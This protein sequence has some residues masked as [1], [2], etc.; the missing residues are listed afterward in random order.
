M[1]YD[2][3]WETSKDVKPFYLIK[4]SPLLIITLNVIMHEASKLNGHR[5][6]IHCLK[7]S[8]SVKYPCYFRAYVKTAI[9]NFDEV[10]YFLSITLSLLKKE[11]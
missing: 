7:T 4:S 3:A 1:I 6:H 10:S 5:H 8:T 2:R 11:E 9:S